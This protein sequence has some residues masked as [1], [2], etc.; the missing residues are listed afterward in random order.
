MPN[1]ATRSTSRLCPR[2]RALAAL[3]APA[4]LL[5]LGGCTELNRYLARPEAT[6]TS[7]PDAQVAD[8]AAEVE[9]P[10]TPSPIPEPQ[11]QPKPGKLY[12]WNGDGRQVT[13]IVVDT[14]AQQARFYVGS[15]QVGWTT[16]ASGV[17]KHPTPVGEFEV[18]E[19]V[20]DKRSNLYG[21]IVKKGGGVVRSSAT[22]RDP[23]PAGGR[24]VGASMPYF[25]RLTYDGIGLHAGPIPK[26][27]R[28]ASHGCIRM[29]KQ[30]APV[31]YAHTGL[32]T[33]VSIVGNGPSYGNYAQKQRAI[34]AERAARQ[35]EER[36]AAKRRAAAAAATASATPPA[37]PKRPAT[38]RQSQP[39]QARE[40]RPGPEAATAAATATA[41]ET[42]ESIATTLPAPPAAAELDSVTPSPA[43]ATRA[44]PATEIGSTPSEA[45][46]AAPAPPPETA[47]QPAPPTPTAAAPTPTP[48]PPPAP[49]SPPPAAPAPPPAPAPPSVETPPASK[50]ADVSHTAPETAAA[51]G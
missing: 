18:M 24:F 23:V 31:L 35:R 5:A 1:H 45:T 2:P 41:I 47:P 26:P 44:E 42:T 37:A 48:T 25:M 20:A 19:K 29:P 12:E 4:L 9:A 16:V 7:P 28:P 33:R 10:A 50:P 14:D 39:E 17:A 49:V 34:A 40:A 27:G 43:A 51:E 46:V 8:A 30:L 32:G 15:E 6:P 11:E 13:H 36:E 3:L 38:A 22:S 21:K